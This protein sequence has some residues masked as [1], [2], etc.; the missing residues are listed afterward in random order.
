MKIAMLCVLALLMSERRGDAGAI[1]AARAIGLLAP[2]AALIY[3]QPDLGTLLVLIA[4]LLV[5]LVVGGTRASVLLLLCA[6]GVVGVFG[7]FHS[8]ALKEYQKARLTAFLDPAADPSGVGYNLNQARI[9]VGSGE[10]FGKGLF[11]GSQTNLSF[12]PEV[13]T[14]FIFVALAE[15]TGF[16]GALVLLG[17]FAIFLWRGLRIAMLSKDVFGTLLA[18]GVVAM[19]AFQVFVNVGMTIG[20]SPI[21]GIPLPFV[22]Y[23]GSSM[24]TTYA[25]TGIL[26]NVHMR[27]GT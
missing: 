9:G 7:V 2:A 10:I 13:H 8:G 26:L 19:I 18:A 6:I 1:D 22:S 23:G 15:E 11:G 25:A 17:L 12:V 5:A 21:T 24:I 27:R 16:V 3:L 20:V 14:D 4:I